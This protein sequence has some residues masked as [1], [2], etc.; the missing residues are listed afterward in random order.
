LLKEERK[1]DVSAEGEK[2]QAEGRLTQIKRVVIR[3]ETARKITQFCL[4]VLFNAVVFGLGPTPILLP[5]IG[6][7]G[8]PTKT[9]GEALGAL[10]FLLYELVFPWLALA[11]IFLLAMLLGRAMCGW[12]CPFG[13]VQDI[14]T[15]VKKQHTQVSPRTHKQMIYI[16]YGVLLV[17]L[18]ISGTAA[19]ASAMNVRGYRESLGVFAK[20]PFNALSPADT[21]FAIMPK[22]ALDVRYA[23]PQMLGQAAGDVYGAIGAAIASI[24]PLLWARLFIMV[25]ILVVV[26]YIPRGWC[27]YVCPQ[28]A[29]SALFSRFSFLGLK[30]DPVRCAKAGCRDCVQV[31]PTLVPILDLP[32]DKFTHSECIYCLKCVDACSTKA[33]KP[34]FP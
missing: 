14:L 1:K 17:V 20:A 29:F 32:W 15:Y 4:F 5:I 9:V 18:F 6:L 34:K 8:T 22:I 30:R 10:Q 13:F 21:L 16:K 11:S 19:L 2:K 25:L 3:I 26:V 33:I 23:V 31:C 24:T 12:A 28:G 7:L 27:R